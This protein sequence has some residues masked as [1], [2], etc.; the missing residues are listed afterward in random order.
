MW[1]GQCTYLRSVSSWVR[2]PRSRSK[3]PRSLWWIFQAKEYSI[4][5]VDFNYETHL[6]HKHYRPYRPVRKALW[7]NHQQWTTAYGGRKV[8]LVYG[9]HHRTNLWIHKTT[10]QTPTV[11]RNPYLPRD[12][13]PLQA[14]LLWKVSTFP[15]KSTKWPKW[16]GI[17]NVNQQLLITRK[18]ENQR[19]RSRSQPRKRQW[20]RRQTR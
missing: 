6:R 11:V 1:D 13:Q 15:C 8:R 14:Y 7:P 12:G 16:N 4:T 10:L 19:Q 9:L 20:K 18:G 17:K 3:T 2:R 5:E